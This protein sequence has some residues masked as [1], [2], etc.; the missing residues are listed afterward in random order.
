[1]N[2][3]KVILLAGLMAAFQ[4]ALGADNYYVSD[5]ETKIGEWNSNIL[6]TLEKAEAENIP[7]VMLGTAF[8]CS[9]CAN[10]KSSVLPNAK[11]KQWVANSPYYFLY[12]Y[13]GSGWWTTKELKAFIDIVGNGGL[14]RVGGYWK[15]KDGTVIK[16]GITGAGLS[17]D[18]VMNYW[19]KL[20]KDYDPNV[21]DQWDPTDDTQGGATSL[22]SPTNTVT[23]TDH[24]Y[25]NATGDKPDKEDWFKLNL[26]AGKQYSLYLDIL[27]VED[28][29]PAPKVD[30]LDPLG[31]VL[32]TL[33][34][35][36]MITPTS[37][38][39]TVETSGTYHIRF[40]Y[41]GNTGRASY[42][43]AYREFE[44]VTFGFKEANVSVKENGGNA[45]LTLTRSGRMTDSVSAIVVTSNGTAVAGTDYTAVS[46]TVTFAANKSEA[47]VNVPIIDIPGN[48]GNKRF[49]VACVNPEGG[50]PD[51]NCTVE[52]EDLDV[53][54]DA[55]DPG[56]DK[57][58]GATEFTVTDE[59]QTVKTLEQASRVVSGQDA[60]DWYKF[61]ALEMGKVYQVKVPAGAYTKRP[62]SATSDPAVL[63]FVG[64]GEEPFATSTL[65]TL[66]AT[67]YRFT[68]QESGDLTILVTNEVADAT[69][70]TYD[71]AWQ[72]WV[73]PVVSFTNAEATV[74]SAGD[75]NTSMTVTLSRTKN[76]EEAITVQ[77]T[78]STV[79]GR[80][81]AT[82]NTV[83]FAAGADTATFTVPLIADGG[84]WEPDETFTLTIL[85]DSAVHQKPEGAIHEQTV[86]L[87]T[88]MPEFDADDGD[89]N[90][91]ASSAKATSLAMGKRPTTRSGLTLNGSDKDD[92]YLFTNVVAGVEYVFELVD[93]LPESDEALPLSVE[94]LLP[95]ETKEV[96]LEECIGATYHFT[97]VTSGSIAIGIHKTAEEPQ[98]LA[99]GLKYREWVPATIGLATNAIEVSEF[100]TSV[101][102]PVQCD[103][104]VPLP[105]TVAVKTQDG[106]AKAGEDYVALDTTVSWDERSPASS[107]KYATVN[108]KRL[109]AEYEGAFEEFSVY[110]D[111]SESE[112]IAGDCTNLTV[113]VL[114]ADIGSVGTFAIAGYSLDD[115]VTVNKYQAKQIPVT[116]GEE[117]KVKV[118]RTGGNAGE[119]G[120]TLTWTD[121]TTAKA[122][123]ADLETEI[124]ID[125]YIPDSE[126]QYVARQIKSLTLAT[127]VK[128]AKTK[129]AKLNFA[130]AD[131]DTPLQAYAANKANIPATS[132][133]NAWYVGPDGLVRTKT[134]AKA[135]EVMTM[136]ASLKGPGTLSFKKI[137]TGSGTITVLAGRKALVLTDQEGVVT[138]QIPAGTQKITITFTAASSGAFLAID[139]FTFTPDDSLFFVGTFYGD[140]VLNGELRG[141]ATLTAK[142]TG[143]VSGKFMMPANQT[144]TVTGKLVDGATDGATVRR[145]KVVLA[146]SAITVA[147]QGE[148]DAK[149]GT[150]TETEFDVIGAR[151]G[152]SDRPLVGAYAENVGVLGQTIA[153]SDED[154]ELT[155][156][157]GANGSTRVTGIYLG[158]R[159]SAS[160]VPFAR[161]G[162]LWAVLVN[163]KLP[164][165]ILFKFVCEDEVWSV[166]K[167]D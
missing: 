54:T 96:P 119:V 112:G 58:S 89:D 125:A 85:E 162:K 24:H 137:Q 16:A 34:A 117:L 53:P 70:F 6:Q 21:N 107:V 133:G 39:F 143:Q 114:E 139:E 129:N 113:K 164:N 46:N 102:I 124:W 118:V 92:W 76:C 68:A 121:G 126:G 148:L 32:K 95:G 99:Y 136:K 61:S 166:T 105:V 156:K 60:A 141:L 19:D 25:M 45:V 20:F 15:K 35:G 81:A 1:M 59:T 50:A 44:E 41:E 154:G 43:L 151:S 62:A 37:C 80:M 108:L 86:T 111:F 57:R 131:A 145:A 98:S 75:K 23:V 47:T 115:G 36:T 120:I 28:G 5:G 134:S 78:V 130:I 77:V 56:D 101:R 100:A 152:W 127:D 52:I 158:E 18:Y 38:V 55:K 149:A 103:M 10:F 132:S 123:M 116:E 165:G 122:T 161:D 147:G 84:M 63:F 26:V 4:F 13:S 31:N 160:V 79:E 17:A 7:V 33:S 109:V 11:F 74:S 73:L 64:A 128:N 88:A 40:Y 159:I 110:L 71:L 144:W 138:A 69:V 42:K 106:T 104:E 153:Y 91:N 142:A 2:W 49:F 82:T 29:V 155:F 65:A 72:E 83:T 67:P 94:V 90:A 51:G 167:E 30:V 135:N 163:S 3:K 48:Q 157:V 27:T 97:P 140:V 22:G 150:G 8:G 9:L 93:V 146:D 87:K 12:G 66:M 14:P